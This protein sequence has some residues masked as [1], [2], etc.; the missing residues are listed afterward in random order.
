M[1]C[2]NIVFSCGKLF[3]K[4]RHQYELTI[5]SCNFSG[6]PSWWP[7]HTW[8]AIQWHQQG[9]WT[10]ATKQVFAMRDSHGKVTGLIYTSVPSYLYNFGGFLISNFSLDWL[11]ARVFMTPTHWSSNVILYWCLALELWCCSC[12]GDYKS[13]WYSLGIPHMSYLKNYSCN[14]LKIDLL[15]IIMLYA[16]SVHCSNIWAFDWDELCKI[17]CSKNVNKTISS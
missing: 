14:L 4:R 12:W 7:C 2:V 11:L 8:Y 17:E 1:S 9:A 13:Y 3:G 15:V 10:D 6:N 16:C 5:L